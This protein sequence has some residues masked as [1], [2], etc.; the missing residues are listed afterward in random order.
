MV[1]LLS[2]EQHIEVRTLAP[3]PILYLEKNEY[4]INNWDSKLESP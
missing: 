3:E 1:G 4:G 2:L